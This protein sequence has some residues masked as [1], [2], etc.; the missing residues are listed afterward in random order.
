VTARTHAKRLKV[1]PASDSGTFSLIYANT[2]IKSGDREKC[3]PRYIST[4]QP[5]LLSGMLEN[6]LSHY[7]LT[8]ARRVTCSLP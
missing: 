3:Q 6:A 8:V 4:P 1:A 2:E 7:A 5:T